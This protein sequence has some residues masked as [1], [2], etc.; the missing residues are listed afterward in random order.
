MFLIKTTDCY[1]AYYFGRTGSLGHAEDSV[2]TV[3][4]FGDQASC[5]QMYSS[6]SCMK[7][8]FIGF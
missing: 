6:C 7:I 8:K 2:V 1:L 4:I 5:E 3:G